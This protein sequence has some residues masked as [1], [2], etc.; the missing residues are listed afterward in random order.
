MGHTDY[1]NRPLPAGLATPD[2]LHYRFRT[3][4]EIQPIARLLA[5]QFPDYHSALLGISELMLN[6]VEHGNLGIDYESKRELMAN[7][8]WKTHIEMLLAHSPLGKRIAR[9]AAIFDPTQITVMV[10]DEGE[11]FDP[12]PYLNL[13]PNAKP[14]LKGRGIALCRLI[15]FDE[16]HYLDGGTTARAVKL[17]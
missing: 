6:A 8:S 15:S 13:P 11:G 4:D 7:G 14:Y 9:I 1:M 10:S 2:A 5:Q 17:L 12:T 3:L 16:L